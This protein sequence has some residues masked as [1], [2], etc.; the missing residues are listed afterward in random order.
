[1][2]MSIA[3]PTERSRRGRR[4]NKFRSQKARRLSAEPFSINAERHCSDADAHRHVE[5]IGEA[6]IWSQ[7]VFKAPARMN[8]EIHAPDGAL[9]RVT[10]KSKRPVQ[11][12]VMGQNF[13][14]L[15]LRLR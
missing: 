13:R 7:Y 10:L 8:T 9:G 5:S 14:L 1:M 6:F 15:T 2:C 3:T 12:A 11:V 4:V